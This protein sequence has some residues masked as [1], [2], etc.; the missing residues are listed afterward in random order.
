MQNSE[1]DAMRV[2]CN[3]ALQDA[4]E[5]ENE[6]YKLGTRIL[7]ITDGGKMGVCFNRSI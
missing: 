5:N 1:I 6:D 7:K 3:V 4:L 2:K